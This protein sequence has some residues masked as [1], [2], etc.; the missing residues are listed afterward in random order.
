MTLY[1]PVNQKYVGMWP[2]RGG[3][4]I[5]QLCVTEEYILIYS[6]VTRNRGI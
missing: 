2:G 3:H 4:Y 1:S 5:P 6:S